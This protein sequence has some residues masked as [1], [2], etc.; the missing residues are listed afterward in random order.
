[1]IVGGSPSSI[2]NGSSFLGGT[3]IV[4]EQTNMALDNI[5]FLPWLLAFFLGLNSLSPAA[6]F[7]KVFEIKRPECNQRSIFY[8]NCSIHSFQNVHIYLSINFGAEILMIDAVSGL[9]NV[10]RVSSWRNIFFGNEWTDTE[11][12]RVVGG[13]RR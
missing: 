10:F 13:S 3:C 11:D 12:A 1:M 2:L 9:L 8:V 7:Q 6:W 4:S 5:S